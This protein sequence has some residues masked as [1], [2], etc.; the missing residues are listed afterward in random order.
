VRLG[1]EALAV[2]RYIGSEVRPALRITRG[3]GVTFRVSRTYTSDQQSLAFQYVLDRLR[4]LNLITWARSER[5]IA[6]TATK[7]AA[8]LVR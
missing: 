1:P 6:I 5:S 7:D 4:I 2:A 3:E 8:V